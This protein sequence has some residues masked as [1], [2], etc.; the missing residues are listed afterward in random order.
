MDLADGSDRFGHRQGD[1][2]HAK[3]LSATTAKYLE[4]FTTSGWLVRFTENRDARIR[5]MAWDLLTEIFDYN[6]LKR[7]P[8]LAQQSINTLLRDGE[9]YCVKISA[10]KFLNKLCDSLIHNCEATQDI[11]EDMHDHVE[12]RRF[13]GSDLEHI[14]VK[15]LLHLCNRQGLISQIHGILNKKDC[16]IVIISLTLRLLS[17]LIQMDFRRSLPVL[18]QLDYW[19]IL[20]DLIDVQS[21]KSQD[22][23]EER[24]MLKYLRE[25]QLKEQPYLFD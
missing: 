4:Q 22:L 3:S 5:V 10:L 1:L 17:R 13:V 24:T 20:V 7:N 14:T 23:T 21:L 19:T 2:T 15:T 9:L 16:P 6:F 8:S 11:N 25:Q 18:T 12:D